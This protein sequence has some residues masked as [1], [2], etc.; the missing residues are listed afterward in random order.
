MCVY[1]YV[2]V[3]ILYHNFNFDYESIT[4]FNITILT[5]LIPYFHYPNFSFGA[6]FPQLFPLTN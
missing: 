3:C 6:Q 4:L 5:V 1:V 2:L